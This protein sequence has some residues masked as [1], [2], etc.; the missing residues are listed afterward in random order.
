[1]FFTTCSQDGSHACNMLLRESSLQ[2]ATTGVTPVM[3][4]HGSH[5][6]N[7]LLRES[8]QECATTGV[9]HVKHSHHTQV[10]QA[11]CNDACAC[12]TSHPFTNRQTPPATDAVGLCDVSVTPNR[13]LH[14]S[15]AA[16]LRWSTE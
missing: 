4:Y 10:R 1:M 9:T 3:C 2:Y 6:C 8:R 16:S 5:A 15:Y 12:V 11:H 13:S 7:M 14:P